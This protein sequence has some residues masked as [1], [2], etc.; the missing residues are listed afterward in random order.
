MEDIRGHDDLAGSGVQIFRCV[1]RMN[2]AADL[3]AKD[4]DK[5]VMIVNISGRG[6]KDMATAGKWFGYLTD[7]Q[8][9]ALDVA[10]AHGNT[11]A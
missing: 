8:A 7:D 5:A 1:F 6:D 9:A 4:Y 11:V 2:A 3:K 10:G